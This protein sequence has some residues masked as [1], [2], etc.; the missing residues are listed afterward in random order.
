MTLEQ[1][2]VEYAFKQYGNSCGAREE[3]V[4]SKQ[5]FI[6]GANSKYVQ[7]EKFKFAI[8]MIEEL[9]IGECR[10]CDS[11]TSVEKTILRLNNMIKELE[12]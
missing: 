8:K 11:I 10:E 3:R 2:A 7:I 5:D 1:E 9:Y 4:I 12:E 6:A